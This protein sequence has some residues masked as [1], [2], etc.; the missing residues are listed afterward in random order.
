MTIT[1]ETGTKKRVKERL[2][3]LLVDWDFCE[4]RS[5]A[6]GLILS[7]KVRLKGAVTDKA[8][9]LLYSDALKDITVEALLP[10]VSRGGLK[11]EKALDAFG[12]VPEA[13]VCLDIGAATGGFTDCL[14]QRGAS[15]VYAI[16]VGYGQLDWKL[17]QDPRVVSMEKTNVRNMLADS[18]PER[19]TLA[20][21]DVSF[22]SLKKVVPAI[23]QLLD[24]ETGAE[25]VLLLK[26]QF[27]YK[28]YL[29]DKGFDGVVRGQENHLLILERVLDDLD[30]ILSGVNPEG[31]NN[32]WRFAGITFSPITGPKGNREFSVYFTTRPLAEDSPEG[33][34]MTPSERQAT[35]KQVV[36]ACY[37][38]I[39]EN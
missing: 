14:L 18:L 9:T 30:V 19:A 11:L 2:D 4:T 36:D 27:E 23:V 12:V 6:Q 1:P 7:G 34:E 37:F 33:V 32:K 21:T 26:P 38:S 13:R 39:K 31:S 29:S 35:L 3:K 15:R 28:D 8:G 20:V 16:D 24:A 10:Y 5:Q 25:M 22:I 17:R